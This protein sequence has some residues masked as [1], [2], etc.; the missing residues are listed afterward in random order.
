MNERLHTERLI[1]RRWRDADRDACFELTSDPVVR[2][3]FPAQLDRAQSDAL[4]DRFE[5]HFQ[6][7]S[8]GFWAVEETASAAFVGFVGLAT[9]GPEYPFGP[10]VEIG[11][12]V[13]PAFWGRGLAI[14]AAQASLRDGFDRLGL[15]EIVA[16]TVLANWRS[17]RVMGALGMTR[18]ARDDFD[19]P[20]LPEGDPL[21]TPRALPPDAQ[22]VPIRRMSPAKRATA[23]RAA[24]AL[25]AQICDAAN[26]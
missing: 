10:A 23:A 14:E 1:L 9:K 25:S 7:H 11:W 22:R 16:F 3:H 15:A 26:S 18:D 19:H 6:Q 24:V 5:A 12:Q 4:V 13:R 20:N 8:F 17:K 21:R 2:E